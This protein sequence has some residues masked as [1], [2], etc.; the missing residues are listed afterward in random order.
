MKGFNFKL[1][2][3][4]E[5]RH[6]EE[7]QVLGLLVNAQKKVR[8]I[9]EKISSLENKQDELYKYLRNQSAL[10]LDKTLIYRSYLQVNRRNIEKT[11]GNLKSQRDQVSDIKEKY[12][13]KRKRR[14]MLEKLKQKEYKIFQK[15]FFLKEQKEL[16]ELGQRVQGLK[17][18]AK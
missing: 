1:N 7:E 6:I 14:E 17:G 10:Q 5:V 16:D 8:E 13:E 15:D 2:K 4:L 9:E 18:A 12:I 3:V 11:K